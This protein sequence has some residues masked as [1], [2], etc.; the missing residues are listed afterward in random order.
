MQVKPH[1]ISPLWKLIE[2]T[3]RRVESTSVDEPKVG[4]RR[5]MYGSFD[6]DDLVTSLLG[7][8]MRHLN[9]HSTDVYGTYRFA[10]AL[11]RAREFDRAR[12]LYLS[13]RHLEI[14]ANTM[15]AMLELKCGKQVE[16]EKYL[17]AYNEHRHKEGRPFTAITL[18][19]I[20]LPK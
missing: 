4:F 2:R 14:S 18:R 15:L 16:A 13:I 6:R 10:G 7:L 17:A 3:E 19:H 9:E 20:A 11:M 1:M 5:N 8:Y 12:E